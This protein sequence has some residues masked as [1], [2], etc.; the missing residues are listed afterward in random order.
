MIVSPGGSKRPNYTYTRNIY[1]RNTY[2]RNF[3]WQSAR[4]LGMEPFAVEIRAVGELD[5][6]FAIVPRKRADALVVM[7]GSL[8]TF[9]RHRIVELAASQM[10]PAV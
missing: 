8:V 5:G 10:L 2:T 7:N 1:T 6:V 3:G 9:E 4:T